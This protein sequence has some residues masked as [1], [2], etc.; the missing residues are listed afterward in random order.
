[1]PEPLVTIG[2]PVRTGGALLGRAIAS[3]LDQT[4][5]ELQV[6]VGDNATEANV[7]RL[8]ADAARED[9]RVTVLRT[10]KP[11]TAV[12]NFARLFEAARGQYFC[13]AA[14]DDLRSR[15]YVSTL[16][17]ALEEE[18]DASLAFSDLALIDA[19]G[20]LQAAR[21]QPHDF[22]TSG[23]PLKQRLRKQAHCPP[24]HVY[25][26]IRSAALRGYP[27]YEPD[28]APDWPL[29]AWLAVRGNFV[30]R[31][32]ATFYYQEAHKTE[33][34]K[35]RTNAFKRLRRFQGARMA[36]VCADAALKAALPERPLGRIQLL[37]S[38]YLWHGRGWKHL[39]LWR[40][41]ACLRRAW[42]RVRGRGRTP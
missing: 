18:P 11:M 25:G 21:H 14:D 27:W 19:G 13:W 39:L 42:W 24:Y 16:V 5:A 41:P 6:L 9:P 31:Q 23:L 30:Y 7:A 1:M 3:V 2:I 28:M 37:S 36:W 8:L 33:E 22:A 15:D 35:S 10:E 17:R 20:D 34:E 12:R 32:G 40:S 38:Y 29:L 26:L 4:H